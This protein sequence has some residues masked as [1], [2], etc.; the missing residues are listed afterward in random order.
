MWNWSARNR[1]RRSRHFQRWLKSMLLKFQQKS[2]ERA[3]ASWVFLKAS[4]NRNRFRTETSLPWPAIGWGTGYRPTWWYWTINIL[5]TIKATLHG[6]NQNV[7]QSMHVLSLNNWVV[8]CLDQEV[9]D[10][11]NV[12][13]MPTLRYRMERKTRNKYW[14]EHEKKEDDLGFKF[15]PS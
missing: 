10:K 7:V 15:R 4:R 13:D 6:M 8:S 9:A 14:V 12:D 11:N 3:T 1:N 5:C 2:T